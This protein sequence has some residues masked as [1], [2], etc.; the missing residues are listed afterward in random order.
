MITYFEI[1]HSKRIF[2]HSVE[3]DSPVGYSAGPLF[4]GGVWGRI[5]V[6]GTVQSG[7]TADVGSID[8]TRKR[9]IA[10]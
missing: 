8:T 4:P 10:H 9:D 3:V 5:A 1:S 7:E 2:E 6:H